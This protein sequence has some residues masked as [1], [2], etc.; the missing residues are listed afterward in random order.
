MEKEA[1]PEPEAKDFRGKRL[2]PPE[3]ATLEMP[4]LKKIPEKQVA[5]VVENGQKAKAATKVHTHSLLTASIQIAH[6]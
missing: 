6:K 3:K 5:Q 4:N 1:T 2:P